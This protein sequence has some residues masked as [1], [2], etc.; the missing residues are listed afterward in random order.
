M[1]ADG[2]GLKRL[3]RNGLEDGAPTWSPDGREIAF[4]RQTRINGDDYRIYVVSRAE[5]VS[6]RSRLL[7][8]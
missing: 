5:A 4:D 1:R 2:I 3:T 7:C 8:S 6:E